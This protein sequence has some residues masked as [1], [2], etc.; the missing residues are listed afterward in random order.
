MQFDLED[1]SKEEL[2]QVIRDA[3]KLV[4]N[5]EKRRRTE[6]RKAAEAA[7]RE[8]GMSLTD[9]LDSPKA[10]R[11][12]ATIKFRNPDNPDETWTGRG[13]KPNWLVRALDSGHS[14][15]EFRI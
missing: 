3:K 15:E 14:I 4:A 2:E 12:P 5:Y 7:A 11:A 13:R 6:A 10:S 8:Y 1:L 9:V